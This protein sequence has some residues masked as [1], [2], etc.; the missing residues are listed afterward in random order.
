MKKFHLRTFHVCPIIPIGVLKNRYISSLCDAS[1][2]RLF[3]ISKNRK[4]FAVFFRKVC[5]TR[6]L[7]LISTRQFN[8]SRVLCRQKKRTWDSGPKGYRS[9]S[10]SVRRLTKQKCKKQAEERRSGSENDRA[11]RERRTSKNRRHCNSR[12]GEDLRKIGS[13]NSVAF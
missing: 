10:L 2:A 1:S 7:S 13:R 12:W 5:Q 11:R 4:Q 9:L 3:L 6:S 8:L